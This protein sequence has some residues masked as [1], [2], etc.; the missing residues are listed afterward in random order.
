MKFTKHIAIIAALGLVP[1]S[2]NAASVAVDFTGPSMLAVQTNFVDSGYGFTV[3]AQAGDGSDIIVSQT[4]N[5][6]GACMN[7]SDCGAS[8]LYDTPELDSAP[9]EIL[10]FESIYSG[11]FYLHGFDLFNLDSQDLLILTV[12]GIDV[13]T[14]SPGSD[15]W[16]LDSS[17]HVYNSF[18][19]R[20]TS[21]LGSFTSVRITSAFVGV[22]PLT[23]PGT[24]G[25]LV[26]GL[27]A[28]GLIR[29]RKS[30]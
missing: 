2:G 27:G 25:M 4:W 16:F 11:G 21:A 23:E 8:M 5:G 6:V 26:F 17:I 24:L 12:D 10:H 15:P 13:G 20:A 3:S 19:L 29:R 22:T 1:L 14:F 28:I 18:A 7:P 30:S 9:E